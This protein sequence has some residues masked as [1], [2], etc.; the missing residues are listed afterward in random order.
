VAAEKD[1]SLGT[2]TAGSSASQLPQVV[3]AT[4]GRFTMASL[5][6]V[7][8]TALPAGAVTDAALMLSVI[9]GA[10]PHD[11]TAA[12]T[13]VPDYTAGL[14][15]SIRG[16]RVGLSPDYFR[17]TYLDAE[18][19]ELHQQPIPLEIE[20]ASCV[21]LA[22]GGGRYCERLCRTPLRVPV[23]FGY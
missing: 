11:S 23:Y 5:A 1:L 2:D 14:E 3:T 19:G 15:E 21:P 6:S 13:P 17:I 9:A 20:N 8:Q 16:L 10:D 22:G 18:T 12:N 7:I 4:Y